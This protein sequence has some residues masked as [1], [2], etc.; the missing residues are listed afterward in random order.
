[1]RGSR[2]LGR[3]TCNEAFFR[4]IISD[5]INLANG[6]SAEELEQEAERMML[7]IALAM[8]APDL[9]PDYEEVYEE[10]SIA[11]IRRELEDTMNPSLEIARKKAE[12]K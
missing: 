7:E 12:A 10:N 8:G 3:V 2:R 9:A 1:M 4:N 6:D 11:Y 5:L